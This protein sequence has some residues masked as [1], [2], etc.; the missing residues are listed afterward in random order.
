MRRRMEKRG[1]RITNRGLMLRMAPL[2]ESGEY[3]V[4]LGRK[5][6]DT[7]NKS[8]YWPAPNPKARKA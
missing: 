3:V 2:I 8:Y 4:A 7:H 5:K 6:T 1:T